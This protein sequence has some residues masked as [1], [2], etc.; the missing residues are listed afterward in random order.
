MA[1][2]K[3]ALG[4][5][6]APPPRAMPA[7]SAPAFS[8]SKPNPAGNG[9]GSFYGDWKRGKPQPITDAQRIDPSPRRR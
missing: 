9:E 5:I 2:Y 3:N 7:E 6:S 8:N 4:G 1:E